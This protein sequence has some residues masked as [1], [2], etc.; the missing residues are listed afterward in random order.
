MVGVLNV[1]MKVL[2]FLLP[3][4]LS[5]TVMLVMAETPWGL[6]SLSVSSSSTQSTSWA[7]LITPLQVLKSPV[8]TGCDRAASQVVQLVHFSTLDGGSNF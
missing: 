5:L 7:H 2:V 1:I 8:R 3:P 4:M 6:S